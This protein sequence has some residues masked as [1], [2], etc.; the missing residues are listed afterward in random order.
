MHA[1]A[2]K[3]GD[4]EDGEENRYKWNVGIIYSG[5]YQSSLLS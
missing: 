4:A 1:D 2:A 3:A 5:Q